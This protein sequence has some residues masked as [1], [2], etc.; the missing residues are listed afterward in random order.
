MLLAICSKMAGLWQFN[1]GYTVEKTGALGI[2]SVEVMLKDRKII[3]T[4]TAEQRL[5]IVASLSQDRRVYDM[6]SQRNLM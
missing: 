5:P 2:R 4:V 1:N 3:V 6:Q